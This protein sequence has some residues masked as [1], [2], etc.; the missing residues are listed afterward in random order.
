MQRLEAEAIFLSY[1]DQRGWDLRTN[2]PHWITISVPR[3][4]NVKW[5]ADTFEGS[6]KNLATVTRVY[7]EYEQKNLAEVNKEG[8]LMPIQIDGLRVNRVLLDAFGEMLANPD[9]SIGLVRLSDEKQICV[10][11]GDD[12]KYLVGAN[13]DQVTTW[14]RSEYWHPEDLSNFNREWAQSMSINGDWFEYRYRS[15][16]PLAENPGPDKCDYTFVSRYRLIEGPNR[17]M[18]HLGEN[19][20]MIEIAGAIA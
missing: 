9:R 19:L 14:K 18:F 16:D 3:W 11:G 5:L 1:L 15:F 17:E 12:G 13:L 10:S 8:D 20:D 2:L 6:L 4:R 7:F